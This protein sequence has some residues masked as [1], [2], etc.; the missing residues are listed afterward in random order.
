M[1]DPGAMGQPGSVGEKGREGV[2]GQ[3]GE[4]GAD[5]E[6]VW[7]MTVLCIIINFVIAISHRCL[8]LAQKPTVISENKRTMRL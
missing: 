5:G 8:F 4:R 3:V 1:G 6:Q 2:T 7:V